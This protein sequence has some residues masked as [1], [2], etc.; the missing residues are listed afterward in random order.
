M[1]SV[2]LADKVRELLPLMSVK[3]Q[4]LKLANIKPDRSMDV[5]VTLMIALN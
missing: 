1:V 2:K 4:H 5:A 3:L